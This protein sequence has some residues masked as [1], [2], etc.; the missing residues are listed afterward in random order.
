MAGQDHFE[1]IEPAGLTDAVANAMAPA[2]VLAAMAS[3]VS[4][5]ALRLARITDRV[6]YLLDLERA[7]SIGEQGAAD[8]ASLRGLAAA[9]EQSM[10]WMIGGAMFIVLYV[11][12]TFILQM[13]SFNYH[14]LIVFVFVLAFIFFLISLVTFA[15]A[16]WRRRKSRSW[17]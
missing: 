2:F 16:V 12:L 7:G 3:W 13:F 10:I 1:L 14:R 5:M 17:I 6:R 11:I 4:V 8:L 9:I 15:W